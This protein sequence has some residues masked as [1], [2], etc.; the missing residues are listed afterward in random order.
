MFYQNLLL[1]WSACIYACPELF[2]FF[3]KQIRIGASCVNKNKL[4]FYPDT[5]SRILN[6]FQVAVLFD[7]LNK[8][9]N[10]SKH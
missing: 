6:G 5:C 7:C 2:V 9:Q 8:N 10:N 4:F 3:F 1:V